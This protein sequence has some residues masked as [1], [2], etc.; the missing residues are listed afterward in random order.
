MLDQL[1]TGQIS[2]SAAEAKLENIKRKINE[3]NTN[4]G[5]D[6][7]GIFGKDGVNLLFTIS[8]LKSKLDQQRQ[9]VGD[10]NAAI[11]KIDGDYNTVLTKTRDKEDALLGEVSRWQK[12]ADDIQ[13]EYDD[14][15][16]LMEKSTDEQVQTYKDRLAKAK[17]ALQQTSMEL[18]TVKIDL[19]ETTEELKLVLKQRE[20][21]MP[22]PD[23]EVAAFM[24]DA[25]VTS[26]DLETDLIYL[27]IGSDDH[28]YAGLTFM[29]FDKTNP[30]PKDGKGKAEIEVF[31]VG[32]RVSA[33]RIISSDARKPITQDDLAVNLI[34]DSTTSN[35]FVVAG[36]FDFNGDGMIDKD[37]KE[38][39]QQLIE[40]W[41]GKVMNEVSINTD[42][43]VFGSAPNI[44]NKPS[45]DQIDRN[46]M[47]EDKYND[48][49]E[50]N[51]KYEEVF[52]QAGKLGVPT[53]NRSRFFNLIG[54]ET[55]AKK[56]SP[57]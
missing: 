38:K 34:W 9:T 18:E 45:L 10:L 21:I 25:K 17:E 37:G 48:A 3:V 8:D 35:K 6:A 40:R 19:T 24:P 20:E 15:S 11:K 41:G 13:A 55:T 22:Q 31:R 27:G 26:V 16:D 33:A 4:L 57:F 5:A 43:I 28:V 12:K 42:F 51:R 32:K 49:I 14:I 39:I 56:I 44:S 23:R 46:P 53:F 54:Y 47:L 1:I 30:R 36:D 7:S 52:V 50:R 2:D 29:I